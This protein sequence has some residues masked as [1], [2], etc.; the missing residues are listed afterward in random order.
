[1]VA[2]LILIYDDVCDLYV[3]VDHHCYNDA[4]Y[5]GACYA[6]F[7][8]DPLCLSLQSY[9]LGFDFDAFCDEGLYY[10]IFRIS[11]Y[12]EIGCDHSHC[13]PFYVVFPYCLEDRF[14]FGYG[15]IRLVWHATN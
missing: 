15:L 10:V 13:F 11:D 12:V 1:M 7:L 8:I 2:I 6:F 5:C 9:Y 4:S 14:S 3:Y